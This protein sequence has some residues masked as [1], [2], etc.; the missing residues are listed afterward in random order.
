M[1]DLPKLDEILGLAKELKAE[2]PKSRQGVKA[3]GRRARKVLVKIR[4]LCPEVRRELRDR[5]VYPV[6]EPQVSGTEQ[7]EAA[8][9]V[10]PLPAKQ[11]SP[12]AKLPT[13]QSHGRYVDL[14]DE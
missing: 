8:N 5:V 10:E 3:A 13:D 4:G 6:E 7:E 1:P 14:S 2:L 11:P 12:K 9:P